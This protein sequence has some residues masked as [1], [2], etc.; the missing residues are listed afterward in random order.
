MAVTEATWMRLALAAS[1][2]LMAITALL[3]IGWFDWRLAA[4]LF[5]FDWGTRLGKRSEEM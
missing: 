3:L 5:P 4:G 1:G 2:F